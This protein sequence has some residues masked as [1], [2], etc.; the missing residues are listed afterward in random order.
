MAIPKKIKENILHAI[1]EINEIKKL[2]NNANENDTDIKSPTDISNKEYN[3]ISYKLGKTLIDSKKDMVS[4]IS[5]PRKLFGIY[6][7]SKNR[8]QESDI[9]Y[10][11]KSKVVVRNVGKLNNVI[12]YKRIDDFISEEIHSNNENVSLQSLINI[13]GIKSGDK[14]FTLS[15]NKVYF[16]TKSNEPIYTTSQKIWTT[17]SYTKKIINANFDLKKSDELDLVVIISFFDDNSK[18]RIHYNMLP[19]NKNLNIAIPQNATYFNLGLKVTGEGVLEKK[20]IKLGGIQESIPITTIDYNLDDGI[21][22]IIPS[23]KGEKTIIDT[24]ESIEKQKNINLDLLEIIIVINGEKDSTEEKIIEF[25]NNQKHLNIVC[26]YTNELGASEARNIAIKQASKEYL[27]F[28][29]DDDL[30][31]DEYLSGLYKI[32]NPESIGFCSIYDMKEDGQIVKDNNINTKLIRSLTDNVHNIEN[33][34]SAITMIA[35]KIIPTKNIKDIVF[36]KSLRSGEDVV[37]FTDY[38][39]R[40]NPKLIM[41]SNEETYY[42]RR[43]RDNSVSRQKM[44]FEFNVSQ[45][46][47]VMKSLLSLKTSTYK[48]EQL[49]FIDSKIRAQCGFIVSYLKENPK[50][51]KN[52]HLAIVKKDIKSFPYRYLQDRVGLTDPSLLVISYCHPPFVDTSAVVAAKR[53]FEFDE[54]CDVVC[55]DMS[56]VRAINPELSKINRH[57]IR[58]SFVLSTNPTFG[59]WSGIYEFASA[60]DFLVDDKNYTSV[61]SR[62]FWPASHFAAFEYKRKHP[63]VKWIAEFSDPIIL[64]IE[65]NARKADISIDWVKEIIADFGLDYSLINEDNL[66]VWCELIV[67]IFADEIIFTCENQRKLMTNSF[68]HQK[69]INRI[70]NHNQIIPHPT[71]PKEFYESNQI[72]YKLDE[73]KVNFAYFGAFYKTRRLDDLIDALHSYKSNV[74]KYKK[75][76]SP[77]IHIFTEQVDAAKEMVEEEGLDKYFIINNYV[78]YFDFLNISKAMDVLIVNDAKAKDMFGFN[79]YLP[80]KLSDYLGSSSKI[81]GFYE[82]N[83]AISFGSKENYYTELSKGEGFKTLI[84]I[85]SESLNR[86]LIESR[87]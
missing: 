85:L 29:D 79:P 31:S 77:L 33:F 52:I 53:V 75:L 58:D 32:R 78:N 16:E 25:S 36:D 5:T 37:F 12:G 47:D 27:V 51:Y 2:S 35:S 3:T 21:S 74:G 70:E 46:L 68:P 66:Y 84:Q 60:I 1:K 20:K 19:I 42:I 48:K 44:S 24:L 11:E 43:L 4:A 22:I 72:D 61:Y 64:D 40:Y 65:G 86:D 76:K 50:E 63:E 56:K 62:S 83:S 73:S 18:N 67:Y 71:L 57:L 54:I 23:Y 39:I 7:E 28:C 80:S 6:L 15:D 81:W 26:S 34:T 69:Y 13:F 45:R 17:S 10:L 9:K 38:Y 30:L 49:E 14:V 87:F 41:C 55:A 8:L 82:K 59:G